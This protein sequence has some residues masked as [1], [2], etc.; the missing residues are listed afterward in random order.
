MAFTSGLNNFVYFAALYADAVKQTK[1]SWA[2]M[3]AKYGY[4]NAFPG[5]N[6]APRIHPNKG[7]GRQDQRRAMDAT[8]P[9]A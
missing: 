5:V 2:A 6:T 7:H 3:A 4:W 8:A 1:L 9:P